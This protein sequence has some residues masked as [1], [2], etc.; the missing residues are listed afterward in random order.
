[1]THAGDPPGGLP[2]DDDL[3]PFDRDRAGRALEADEHPAQAAVEDLLRRPLADELELLVVLHEP[4]HRRLVE[5]R[6]RVRV[7]ADDDVTLLEPQDPLR[8]E[9]ERRCLQVGA[10]L[11]QR[12]PDVLGERAREVQL[13][14]EL[15]DEAN[16]QRQRLDS[17]DRHLPGIEVGDALVREVVVGDA[18]HEARAPAA[19]RR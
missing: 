14:A 7:L 18:L 1:M 3:T 6:L 15:A 10:L 13:V 9:P 11:E 8:L 17:G 4:R 19:R 5:V 2:V 16:P 12:V